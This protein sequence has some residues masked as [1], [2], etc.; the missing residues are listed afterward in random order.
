MST[1]KPSWFV[2]ALD[3]LGTTELPGSSANPRIMSYF[4]KVQR[5]D[6]K[7]DST[8]WCAAYLGAM[9][10]DAG[11]R[12]TRSLRARSYLNWG[13]AIT[14]ARPGAIAIFSRGANPALGHVGFVVRETS[15]AL[16]ILGGNQSNAVTIAT[17]AKSRLLGLRW[18][19][20]LPPRPDVNPDFDRALK[21]V[22]VWE[23]GYTDDPADPGGP[24][25]KGVTLE[26]F[27]RH[28][29]EPFTADRRTSLI[30]RLKKISATDVRAIYWHR[31]WVRS[32]AD[33]LAPALALMH[34]DCAVNQ[35]PN[36]AIRFLQTAL[37]VEVD[38]EVGPITLRAAHTKDLTATLT[39]Y[40]RL[41]ENHYES[42]DHFWRFGRGWLNR[43]RATR[44]HAASLQPHLNYQ[45]G[46]SPMSTPTAPKWWG[47]S[48]TVWGTI[49]T[50]LSTVLPVIGPF[51]GL[52]ITAELIQQ[53]GET[54]A[55]LLQA[56][57][58]VIGVIMAIYGRFRATAP[59]Q[60][61]ALSFEF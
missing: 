26:V 31:Y 48:L 23:G 43:L 7:D 10:E 6:I 13:R 57:G 27:A 29:G 28:L 52:D 33:K 22:L 3:E 40:A 2:A 60:R 42:L 8:A 46:P 56:I 18:P 51:I 35:G 11:Y 53:L 37:A 44:Q 20:E 55:R 45:K 61:R 59:L 17:Y 36:R 25:N 41:R 4:R 47:E 15:T 16:L 49:V 38:G 19:E 24:T 54:V 1:A 58:G 9:I 21:H 14:E 12:S 39:E 30:R 50:A 32:S 34:F 5:G